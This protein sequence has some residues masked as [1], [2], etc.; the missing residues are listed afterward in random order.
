LKRQ[1]DMLRVIL[2]ATILDIAGANY[3]DDVEGHPILPM[4][5]LS[6][7]EVFTDNEAMGRTDPYHTQTK[8]RYVNMKSIKHIL[9]KSSCIIAVLFR[10]LD[11]G[12]HGW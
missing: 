5:G 2:Y 12:R 8:I 11:C 1:I 3:P 9:L 4:E 7:L 10:W 6:L